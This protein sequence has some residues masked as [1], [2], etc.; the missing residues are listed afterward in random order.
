VYVA[1]DS[2]RAVPF[3]LDRLEVTGAPVPV[4]MSVATA[5]R[6]TGDFDFADDGTLVYVPAEGGGVA[7][8]TLTWVDR[9]GKEE[10]IPAPARAY[11]YPR[12]SP[13]GTRVALDVREEEEDIWVWDLR[14]NGLTRVTNDPWPDRTP[15]WTADGASL[16]F[17][18]NR[19]TSPSLFRQRA[20]G[21]GVAE[22]ISQ[23][24][25]NQFPLSLSP[26]GKT[27]VLMEGP[28]GAVRGDLMTIDLD[29]V[30]RTRRT[31]SAPAGAGEP[32]AQALV[33]TQ[34]LVKTPNGEANGAIS[35]DG[36]WLAYQANDSG[37]WDV[38]VQSLSRREGVG[39]FTVSTDGGTQP[40]WASDG[41]E[42]FYISPRNEMM[43]VRVAGG[44]T[45]A[46]G[47]PEKIF[48]ASPYYLTGP[49]NPFFMYD[50][51]RDGRFLMLKPVGESSTSGEERASFVVVQHWFEELKRLFSK[52]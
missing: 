15:V 8:R 44:D 34:P 9:Q 22:Q 25:G 21:T 38:Y 52:N 5:L 51:A 48:D 40:R 2:L 41:R 35:P 3:D 6:S 20:D 23:A 19:A 24:T 42:L 50:V 1:G 36:R 43:R 18:S 26:N 30:A 7:R 45:W 28:A 49:N 10:A 14:R 27:L 33:P 47:K 11:L 39:R 12:I 29:E 17:T 37:A 16:V 32:G 4:P 46:A 13:D 31:D